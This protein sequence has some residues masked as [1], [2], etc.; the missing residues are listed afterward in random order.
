MIV[1][2]KKVRKDSKGTITDFECDCIA[3]GKTTVKH[4]TKKQLLDMYKTKEVVTGNLK[5]IPKPGTLPNNG[6]MEDVVVVDI[7]GSN[8]YFR[9][10]SDGTAKDNLV[11]YPT[12]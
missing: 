2:I 6:T 9:A 5:G 8:P 1:I 7:N 4:L 11:N 3:N 10:K 12:F